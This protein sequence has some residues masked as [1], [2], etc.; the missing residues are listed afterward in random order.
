MA[1]L[2][3]YLQ[4]TLSRFTKKKPVANVKARCLSNDGAMTVSE[5]GKVDKYKAV[6]DP[7]LLEVKVLSCSSPSCIYVAF[8]SEEEKMNK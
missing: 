6:K 4:S 2:F 7:L 3:C 1:F 8:L 5:E